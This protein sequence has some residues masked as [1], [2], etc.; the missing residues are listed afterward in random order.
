MAKGDIEKGTAGE[1]EV[2]AKDIS[3]V[4]TT[5]QCLSD[6]KA[7]RQGLSTAEAKQRLEQYGYNQLTAKDKKTL[8]QR[9]WGQVNNILVLILVVVAIVSASKA[10]TAKETE[11]LITN[12]LEVGLIVFVITLNA[13]IGIMQVSFL[14][15]RFSLAMCLTMILTP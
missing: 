4:L 13:W 1:E 9:I 5:E 7:T 3:H 8:L 15:I 14:S 10:V 12:W 6:L 2:V 11:D